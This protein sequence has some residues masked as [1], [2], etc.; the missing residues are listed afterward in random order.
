L[1]VGI[2]PGSGP[3]HM[4]LFGYDPFQYIVGR[5]VL[6]ALG[7]GFDLHSSDVAVR[8]NYATMNEHGIIIDRRAGRIST[9][10]NDELCALLQQIVLPGIEIF[11]K[12]VKE[13]RAVAIFRGENLSGFLDDSD[14][15]KTGF[16]PKDV[17]PIPGEEQN[18]SAQ[19]MAHIANEFIRQSREILK[20]YSPANCIL[21]RGFDQ[22]APFPTMEERY[23]LKAAAIAV[24]PMY[25][26]VARLVG[27]DVLPTKESLLD[28]IHS[29][30]QHFDRYTFFFLHIKKTDSAGEDGNFKKKVQAIEEVDTL[31]PAILKIEPDVLV[32]T[33]DHS[34][35]SVLKGHSWHPVPFLLHSNYCRPDAVKQFSEKACNLGGLGCFPA[36]QVMPLALANALKL[37]KYG[38]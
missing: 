12:P 8:I 3:A 20:E 33:G 5:G 7:V 29:V 16:K 1:G 21:L 18:P 11:V 34:T 28:E 30:I 31:I 13:H 24:Y 15:Q 22:Y 10:T 2:T 38:A 19:T 37:K 17:T 6:A 9:T 23:K 36:T 26:G 14:P 32:I 35:P 25:Q 27:M 4:A